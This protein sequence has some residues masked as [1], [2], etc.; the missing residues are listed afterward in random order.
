MP[1]SPSSSFNHGPP[2]DP[3]RLT[4]EKLD[5]DRDLF[6]E[7]YKQLH[8]LAQRQM[9]RQAP[10]HTLQPTALVNEFWLKIGSREQRFQDSKHFLR[11]AAVAMNH[12]LVDHAKKRRRKPELASEWQFDELARAFDHRAID[13]LDLNEA[14]NRLEGRDS[15]LAE[16]VRLRFFTGRT[17]KESAETLGISERHARRQFEIARSWL[18][19][20]LG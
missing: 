4:P 9:G 2:P 13:L 5:L 8:H 14:L 17:A 18:R 7:L 6:E 20:E 19:R 10:D 3:L 12:I 15:L 1:E 16:L 11:Y